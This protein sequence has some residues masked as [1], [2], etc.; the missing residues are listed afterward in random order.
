[1]P[2]P[3][4]SPLAQ[5]FSK[6]L[7]SNSIIDPFTIVME[8][9]RIGEECKVGSHCVIENNVIVGDRV[10][11]QCG[12]QLWDGVTIEDDVFV[13]PNV[14]FTNYH[15]ARSSKDAKTYLRTTVKK[16][17][18]VGAGATLLP[19]IT[20]GANA[21]VGAGSVVTSDVPP[22]SVVVG[23]PARIVR[24]TDIVDRPTVSSVPSDMGDQPMIGGA[25][26]ISLRNIRDA[27]GQL[28]VAQWDE[29]L[30]FDPVRIFFIH[31]VPSAKVRG[32]HA[33]RKCLQILVALTGSARVV[34]DDG[35][36]RQEILLNQ[37]SKA[38]L[39]P[40]GI[41]ATQYDY[42]TDCVLAVFASH[43][44]EEADYIRDYDEF[45]EYCKR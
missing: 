29:H 21:I 4:I 37:S 11:I 44:Y 31:H 30:P 9:A 8:G 36:R 33:H 14:S 28:T 15:F 10:T 26:W 34:I 23:N 42:T 41:W 19:G 35:N 12:V 16:G 1:M 3:F 25:K 45:V 17:A 5:V 32:G 43:G 13:G 24:Y 40:A 39:I 22:A 6:H 38:I 27:R 7:G 2:S 18:S 20:I